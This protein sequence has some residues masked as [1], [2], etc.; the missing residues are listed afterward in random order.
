MS[1]SANNVT[2]KRPHPSKDLTPKSGWEAHV[3]LSGSDRLYVVGPG[4]KAMFCAYRKNSEEGMF[5]VQRAVEFLNRTRREDTSAGNAVI[6]DALKKAGWV[7]PE[8]S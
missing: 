8:D 3:G 7:D 1:H 6:K 2:S 4:E 5:I